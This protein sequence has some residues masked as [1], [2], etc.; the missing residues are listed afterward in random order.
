MNFRLIF[1]AYQNLSTKQLNVNIK[2]DIKVNIKDNIVL[3]KNIIVLKDEIQNVMNKQ[4]I[5]NIFL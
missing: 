4:M 2:V 3:Y 1:H 5:E